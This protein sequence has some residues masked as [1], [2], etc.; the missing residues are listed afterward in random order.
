MS[1]KKSAKVQGCATP[2]IGLGLLISVRKKYV[3]PPS[4]V[5]K[6]SIVSTCGSV[7]P[8]P[9]I[10]ITD[11]VLAPVAIL[12]AGDAVDTLPSAL[13]VGGPSGAFC[14]GGAV[15]TY[16]SVAVRALKANTY[17]NPDVQA[18]EFV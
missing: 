18:K 4:K 1:V 14:P 9:V 17:P 11:P 16:R 12:T 10:K 3:A 8:S 13:P 6:I 5:R 15:V 7:L 2:L